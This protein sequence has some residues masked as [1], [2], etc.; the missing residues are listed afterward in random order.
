MYQWATSLRS[1]RFSFPPLEL[2]IP[3]PTHSELLTSHL[4][5][6]PTESLAQSRLTS[7]T[8]QLDKTQT[9]PSAGPDAFDVSVTPPSR[10]RIIIL[11]FDGTCDQFDRAVRPD[12][13][14]QCPS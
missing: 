7:F 3:V 10:A 5:P 2:D 8:D 9:P 6:L 11:C 1:I 4:M 12:P 14:L 13:C